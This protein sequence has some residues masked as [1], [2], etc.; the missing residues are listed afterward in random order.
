MNAINPTARSWPEVTLRDIC[1]VVQYGYT[2][3]ATEEEVGP[4]FLRITDIVPSLIDWHS[5]P[6]CEIEPDRFP[7]Y[8]VA[9]GDIVVA[10]T[11][12]TVGYAKLLRDPPPAVFASYLVRVRAAD[13]VDNQFIGAVMESADYKRFIIANAGGAA[14]PNANAQVLTSY[15]L[16]LPPLTVQR[17]ISSIIYTYN[18]LIENNARRIE[19][20]EEMARALYRE[21]FVEFRFPG[22]ERVGMVNS[23]LGPIPEAWEV[24]SF[25]QVATEKRDPARPS[26]LTEALP[27]MPLDAIH[28]KTL[29]V[30]DYRPGSEAASSLRLFQEG[31]VLFGAMR[32]YFHKVCIAPFSGV[33]RS[34]CLVLRPNPGR[35]HF[36]VAALSEEATVA[37]AAAHSTGSTIPYAKWAGVLSEM[38]LVV[39]P[40]AL[41]E[42]FG[43]LVGPMWLFG[44]NLASCNRV[45]REVHDLLLPRLVSGEIDVSE[46]AEG[47]LVSV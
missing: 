39:P 46:A 11:G 34:T 4:K 20:L 1:D 2:A 6:H 28:P 37:Y 14:Q 26:A 13:G 3:S 21:W 17:R 9:D 29:T 19:I 25:G 24:G 43:Q 38:R 23:E 22:H 45:L 42:R 18:D 32:A 40:V 30:H 47:S 8:R 7:T 5:V 35:Y 10:R 41:C 31:D 27:Y 33:T 12:A 15:P 16:R 44:Q 36:T